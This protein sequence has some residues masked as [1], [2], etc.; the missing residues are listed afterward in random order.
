M[1]TI[2]SLPNISKEAPLDNIFLRFSKT[3]KYLIVEKDRQD[4]NIYSVENKGEKVV[5]ERISV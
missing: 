4:I 1:F 2:R 3:N 5:E